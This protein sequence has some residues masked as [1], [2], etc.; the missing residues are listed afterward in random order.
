MENLTT[1]FMCVVLISLTTMFTQN[2]TSMDTLYQK[3]SNFNFKTTEHLLKKEL[4]LHHITVFSEIDHSENAMN[5]KT[6][7]NPSKVFIIGNAKAGTPLMLEDPLI[8]IELPLKILLVEDE[9]KNVWVY[10]KNL[11]P[12]KN[13]YTIRKSV[14]QLVLIDTKMHEIINKAC[15]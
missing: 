15:K 3:Q 9:Q 10:Y 8:A 1:H 4:E 6:N 7:M 5:I 12:L 13:T 14:A 2:T 11:R